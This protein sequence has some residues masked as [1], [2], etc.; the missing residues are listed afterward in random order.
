MHGRRGV[1]PLQKLGRCN[2]LGVS[3]D[4]R[5]IFEVRNSV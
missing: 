4:S 5:E 3:L 2:G 1:R